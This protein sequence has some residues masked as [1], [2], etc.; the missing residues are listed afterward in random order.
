LLDLYYAT[1]V[2][3]LVTESTRGD[4]ILDL[5]FCNDVSRVLNVR[6][7]EPFN[8]SDHNQAYFDIV[9]K[10]STPEQAFNSYDFEHADWSQI[11]SFLK[12]IDFFDLFHC[13][14]LPTDRVDI[15]H[16][17][18]VAQGNVV[19]AMSASYGKSL[20]STL[21]RSQTP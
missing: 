11:R 6:V 19:R 8:T 18:A 20:Y 15:S 7:A 14:L 13:D 4:H 1:G 17:T 16:A 21:R 10:A 9:C 3:Q 5:I 12:N 2:H